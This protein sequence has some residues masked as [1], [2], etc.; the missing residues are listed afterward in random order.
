MY[1]K[2][3]FGRYLQKRLLKKPWKKSVLQDASGNVAAQFDHK[4][5]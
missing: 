1:L 5:K 2:K 4:R 3:T